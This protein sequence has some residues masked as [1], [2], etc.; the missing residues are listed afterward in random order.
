MKLLTIKS[1]LFLFIAE[2]TIN[3]AAVITTTATDTTATI[4]PHDYY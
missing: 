1:V 3:A 4:D 2:C